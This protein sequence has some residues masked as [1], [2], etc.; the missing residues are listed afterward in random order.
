MKNSYAALQKYKPKQMRKLFVGLLILVSPNIQVLAEADEI[1]FPNDAVILSPSP[2]LPENWAHFIGKWGNGKWSGNAM[3]VEIAVEN[4]TKDGYASFIYA[5]PDYPDWNAKAGYQRRLGII[6]GSGMGVQFRR[7]SL[8]F[9]T[10]ASKDDKLK[11]T[12]MATYSRRGI[13]LERQEYP[14]WKRMNPAEIQNMFSGNTA[15]IWH[16]R[17]NYQF[18]RYYSPDG[19]LITRKKSSGEPFQ[20]SWLINDKGRLCERPKKTKQMLCQIVAK[21]NGV[22]GRFF[23]RSEKKGKSKVP[24]PVQNYTYKAFSAGN[25][26]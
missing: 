12:N 6:K 22:I 2:D 24:L 4:I 11:G 10:P 3:P 5:I 17:R 19:T 13:T 16:E 7:Y 9:Y 1:P 8:F 14:E 23:I 26:L 20:G 25:T 15:T 18:E 21:R